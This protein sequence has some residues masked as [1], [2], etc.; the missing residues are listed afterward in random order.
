MKRRE[1]EPEE[2]KKKKTLWKKMENTVTGD[3]KF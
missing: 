1:R 3:R 2:K